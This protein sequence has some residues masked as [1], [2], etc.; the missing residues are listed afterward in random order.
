MN[1]KTLIILK[2]LT[3]IACLSRAFRWLVWGMVTN[4][5]GPDPTAA[6][7]F[8]TG[9]ATICACSPSRWPSR[10]CAGCRRA[11]IG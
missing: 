5:L 6:I 4:N 10:R 2:T 3:W 11:S 7:A 1:R 8:A 9:K